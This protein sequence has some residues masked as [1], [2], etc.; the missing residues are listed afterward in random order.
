MYNEAIATK[1][2]THQANTHEVH[3]Y[4][5]YTIHCRTLLKLKHDNKQ[6]RTVRSGQ[7]SPMLI[8]IH[9][10]RPV[11][12]ILLTSFVNQHAKLQV[13]EHS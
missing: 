9:M 1:S 11:D 7:V 3:I 2:T 6:Y 5:Q 13:T 8:T 12:I 4:V 10:L